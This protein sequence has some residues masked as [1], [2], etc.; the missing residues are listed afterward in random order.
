MAGANDDCVNAARLHERPFH[1]AYIN[2]K[3][4]CP[5]PQCRRDFPNDFF[6]KSEPY[7][8]YNVFTKHGDCHNLYVAAK[9]AKEAAKLVGMVLLH[10]GYVKPYSKG[11]RGE[12]IDVKGENITTTYFQCVVFY[13]DGVW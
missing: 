3:I 4:P 9:D 10:F 7:I 8:G 11:Y 6:E 13:Q 2:E 5:L 12:P 1:A